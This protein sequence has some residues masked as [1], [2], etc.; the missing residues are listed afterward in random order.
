MVAQQSWRRRETRETTRSKRGLPASPGL[1]ERGARR[2]S[3]PTVRPGPRVHDC[4]KHHN[5]RER[6]TERGGRERGTLPT[7]LIHCFSHL[8]LA[9]ISSTRILHYS[10][11]TVGRGSSNGGA[12]EV[13]LPPTTTAGWINGVKMLPSLRKWY[14]L[15][16]TISG[17]RRQKD[18]V[19]SASSDV[20]E[21]RPGFLKKPENS[22]EA[23]T[24]VKRER[25][26]RGGHVD[27]S[28]KLAR[29]FRNKIN[30]PILE[31][32]GANG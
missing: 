22:A 13:K 19:D 25:E 18:C 16:C 29:V 1:P 6:K 2:T 30:T 5:G 14:V 12:V 9:L 20:C 11:P 7:H 8:R 21:A 31:K 24:P 27:L 10:F 3:A 28:I 32:S 23:R 26:C 4:R 17:M 15:I